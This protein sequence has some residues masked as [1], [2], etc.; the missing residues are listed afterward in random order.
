MFENRILLNIL[1]F[2][3]RSVMY[4][5]LLN[6]DECHNGLQYKTGLNTLKPD[7]QFNPSGNCEAGGI[8][9][10]SADI[11]EFLNFSYVYVREVTL[12]KDAKIYKNPGKPEKWKSDKVILGRKHRLDNV[13]IIQWMLDNG[14]KVTDYALEC[15]SRNGYYKVVKLLIE[16]GAKATDLALE[17]T[18]GYGHYEVV[19]LLLDNGATP[20]NYALECAS[21]NGYYKVVKLLIENGAK[22]TDR[23]LEYASENGH[24]EVVKLLLENGAKATDRALEWASENGQYKTVKLLEKHMKA[25]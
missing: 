15:A 22:A 8:Y 1:K 9:F 2:N 17:W 24:Y 3:V 21:R 19:K 6:K 23:A 12:P 11:F 10:A 25:N 7:E 4:F 16:N 20:T 14:A 13:K 5:K 18:S